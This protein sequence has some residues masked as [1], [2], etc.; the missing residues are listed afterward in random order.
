[1]LSVGLL[2]RNSLPENQ[3]E[4]TATMKWQ[5]GVVVSPEWLLKAFHMEILPKQNGVHSVPSEA[6]RWSETIQTE[7]VRENKTLIKTTTRPRIIFQFGPY[8]VFWI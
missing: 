2:D 1:M 5:K 7:I 3:N 6:E 8:F 4:Q